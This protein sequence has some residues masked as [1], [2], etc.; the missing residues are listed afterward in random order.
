VARRLLPILLSVSLLGCGY[1]L[2][3]YPERGKELAIAIE[4]FSNESYEPGY[5][6]VISDAFRREV[7]R[8]GALR[9]VN[10]PDR[11]NM[12][13]RGHIAPI[14]TGRRS[15]SSVVLTLEYEVIVSLEVEFF[16][17]GT[18]VG[19]DRRLL[20]EGQLYNASADVEATRKNREEALSLVATTL[21]TRVHDVIWEVAPP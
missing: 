1:R 9:L 8:R 3:D 6:M 13:L 17:P 10:D 7:A 21:A 5:E 20:R 16:R 15:F 12:I 11:A 2:V 18:E 4:N 14:Q 19:L